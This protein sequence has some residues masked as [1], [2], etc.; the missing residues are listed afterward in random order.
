MS[1]GDNRNI[2]NGENSKTRKKGNASNNNGSIVIKIPA[3]IV[4]V[5]MKGL[6]FLGWVWNHIRSTQPKSCLERFSD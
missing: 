4:T 2:S 3:A 1:N 6:G 5:V